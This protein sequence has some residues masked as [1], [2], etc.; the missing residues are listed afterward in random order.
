MTNFEQL[1]N[2]TTNNSPT[3]FLELVKDNSLQNLTS[4]FIFNNTKNEVSFFQ[5]L[6]FLAEDAIWTK[7][8]LSNYTFIAQTIDNDYVL[9]SEKQTLVI[10]YSCYKS[11]SE[12]FEDN[13]FD[14]FSKQEQGL[15]HSNILPK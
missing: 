6:K 3:H 5:T 2:S 15:L 7:D 10:P 11:D 9:A 4:Y 12:L 14:F 1:A 8:E 13:V